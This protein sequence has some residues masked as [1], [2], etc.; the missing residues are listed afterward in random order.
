MFDSNYTFSGKHGKLLN[1]L[2]QFPQGA[3]QARENTGGAKFFERYIDVYMNAA[4]FGLLYA[5]KSKKDSS[6]RANSV[7]ILASAF[8]RERENCIFLYRMVMLLAE[9]DKLTLEE[10]INRAFYYDNFTAEELQKNM[11]LFNDYV[12]GG[13]EVMYEKFT[14]DCRTPEDYLEKSYE[15]ITAFQKELEGYSYKDEIEKLINNA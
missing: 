8:A 13:I 10:R 9:S 5:R 14:E 15:V 12:R 11:E 7:N 6:P 1:F 2:A 3:E 4:V